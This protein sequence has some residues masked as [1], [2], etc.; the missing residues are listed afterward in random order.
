MYFQVVNLQ[1]LHEGGKFITEVQ[2]FSPDFSYFVG[3]SGMDRHPGSDG[4]FGADCYIHHGSK[5]DFWR[6][7]F[8]LMVV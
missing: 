7:V 8:P 2:T 6:G 5:V 1:T 3:V 4:L